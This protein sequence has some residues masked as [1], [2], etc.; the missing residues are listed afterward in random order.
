VFE[1]DFILLKDNKPFK[2]ES[3]IGHIRGELEIQEGKQS[4]NSCDTGG[5]STGSC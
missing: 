2:D 3:F 1:S 4:S 5:C